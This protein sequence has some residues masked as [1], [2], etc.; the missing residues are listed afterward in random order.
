VF[1]I[2]YDDSVLIIAIAVAIVILIAEMFSGFR[3]DTITNF[4][5][6]LAAGYPIME[7]YPRQCNANGQTFYEIIISVNGITKNDCDAARGHWTDCGSRCQLDSQGLD[8]IACTKQCEQLCLCSGFAGFGCPNNTWC[9]LPTG[10]PDLR[11]ALGY[12]VPI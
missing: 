7:S 11:D 5:E 6:C 4:G 3:A 8:G 1:E 9:K 10:N 2:K 12:C